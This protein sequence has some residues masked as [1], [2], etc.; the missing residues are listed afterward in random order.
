[1]TSCNSMANDPRGETP[2]DHFIDGKFVNPDPHGRYEVDVSKLFSALWKLLTEKSG[3]ARPKEH[4][5][6]PVVTQTHA[7]LQAL[8]DYSVIRLL[9]STLLFK[10]EERFWL[11]DPVF[12]D[13]ISPTVLFSNKRF[14]ELP[15]TLEELPR[16]EGVILSHNHYDHLD[17][18]SI[19][20]L[21]KRVK[22]FFVPLGVAD[23]L[24]EF[25]ID[26]EK[27]VELD[28]WQSVGHGAFELAATP[29]QHFSGRGLFDGG[30]TLWC[31]WVITAPKAR[32]FFSGDSG[33]F[34]GFKKIGEQY[35]PFDMTFMEAGAYNEDW[36]AMHLM[37]HES[38]RAHIDLKGKI[39]FP[40]H[41][42]SFDL[43]L[44]SWYEPLDAVLA[45]AAEQGVRVT[46][47]KMGEAVPIL[48][49]TRS[50]TWWRFDTGLPGEAAAFSKR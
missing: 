35:G 7:S 6:I 24:R 29:A 12:S 31:S 17:E 44:H 41:N 26:G 10:M 20:A 28:W 14:H 23:A 8:P 39:M 3:E 42:S 43:A 40:I 32:L 18:R 13:D 48:E 25:G 49:Y 5:V 27:I 11:I 38:V 21:K 47:P 50:G 2:S 16:I 19:K 1:M 30:K 36:K 45:G 37:P 34:D 46:I 15:I 4:Q 22:K 9:H 33:Y